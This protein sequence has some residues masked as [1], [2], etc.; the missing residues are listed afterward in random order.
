MMEN[1]PYLM[2]EYA[3]KLF[4]KKKGNWREWAFEEWRVCLECLEQG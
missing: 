4:K 2:L 1:L 3:V